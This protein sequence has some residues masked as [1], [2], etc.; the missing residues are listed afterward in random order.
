AFG[1]NKVRKMRLVAAEAMRQ[2]ADT[3]ITCGGIQSNHARVTAAAAARLG[4]D[5]ILVLSGVAHGTTPAARANTLLDRMVG[6]QMRYVATRDERTPEMLRA[7]PD[8]RAAGRHPFVI[9]LGA[10]TPLGA[11]AFVHAVAE[12]LEQIEPPDVIVHASSSG[13]TQAGLIAG[14]SLAGVPTR[15]LGMSADE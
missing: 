10:S 2:G 14:C 5:C 6:A 12:L 1:G 13:G 3:L 11:A 15:V 4:L 9:P 7:A 8:V